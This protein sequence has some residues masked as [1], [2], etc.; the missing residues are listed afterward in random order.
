MPNFQTIV[1]K[2]VTQLEEN[3]SVLYKNSSHVHSLSVEDRESMIQIELDGKAHFF[4]YKDFQI[5]VEKGHLD[6]VKGLI[7][8]MWNNIRVGHPPTHRDA[9]DLF[10]FIEQPR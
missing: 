1:P 5:P 6:E 3:L 7:E 4:G 8:R 9:T 2:T 10:H